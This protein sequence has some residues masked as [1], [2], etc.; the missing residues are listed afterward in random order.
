MSIYLSMAPQFVLTY[1]RLA[2]D[3]ASMFAYVRID[4]GESNGGPGII[5]SGKRYQCSFRGEWLRCL[6]DVEARPER[7]CVL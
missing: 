5:N 2:V 3:S 7:R 4:Q 1:L 6:L